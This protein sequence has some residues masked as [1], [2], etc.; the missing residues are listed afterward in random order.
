MR[1]VVL[2][3]SLSGL[4]TL[5]VPWFFSIKSHVYVLLE[6]TFCNLNFLIFSLSLLYCHVVHLYM[7]LSV[8]LSLR[9]T[10]TAASS[11]LE[12]FQRVADMATSTRGKCLPL[13]SCID[14]IALYMYKPVVNFCTTNGFIYALFDAY[15][16]L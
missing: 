10:V 15:T 9:S 14:I 4:L 13:C 2:R 5:V 12:A 11:F 1:F 7:P 6:E 16:T 8:L 3:A